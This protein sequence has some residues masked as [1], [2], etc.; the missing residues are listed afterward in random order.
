MPYGL[1]GYSSAA[2]DSIADDHRTTG[3]TAVSNAAAVIQRTNGNIVKGK[4]T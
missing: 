3:V 4:V 2:A 1:Y